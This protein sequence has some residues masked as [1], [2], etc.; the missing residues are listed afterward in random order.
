[1]LKQAV[2]EHEFSHKFPLVILYTSLSTPEKLSIC[3]W[4]PQISHQCLWSFCSLQELYSYNPQVKLNF[5]SVL[6]LL[7]LLRSDAYFQLLA[8][9]KMAKI[10]DISH[11]D[12]KYVTNFFSKLSVLVAHSFIHSSHSVMLKQM[13]KEHVK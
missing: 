2:S 7:D 10:L 13:R 6:L 11:R 8:L 12:F 4:F 1:M 5:D 9:N 3:R